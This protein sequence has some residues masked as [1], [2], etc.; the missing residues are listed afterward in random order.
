MEARELLS[1]HL[2]AV[3]M[4]PDAYAVARGV[5]RSIVYKFLAGKDIRL[6]TWERLKPPT[7][8]AGEGE[9]R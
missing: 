7:P 2:Q 5:G 9:E 6:S 8:A 4:T 1:S 3:G